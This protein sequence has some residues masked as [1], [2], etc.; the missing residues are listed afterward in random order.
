MRRILTGLLLLT[1]IH[2]AL[3]ADAEL[4]A[5]TVKRGT[6]ANAKLIEDTKTGVASQIAASGCTKLGDVDTYVTVMPSGEPG[7][8]HWKELWI[9]SGCD[10]K[11]PIH[12]SFV[13]DATGASWSLS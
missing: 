11:F 10:K 8:R 5:G 12:I 2:S 3:A 1:C 9:V 13:E 7:R 6:L 4:P